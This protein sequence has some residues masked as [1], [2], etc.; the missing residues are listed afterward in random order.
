[1]AFIVKPGCVRILE[2][3]DQEPAA[4]IVLRQA[5]NRRWRRLA[6]RAGKGA[7]ALTLVLAAGACSSL[8]V[9]RQISLPDLP[10]SAEANSLS[11]REHQRV[12]SAYGGVYE[13]PRLHVKLTTIVESLTAHSERPDLHY[14]ITILNSPAVNAFA[15]PSGQLYVTRGLARSRQR[16]RRGRLGDVP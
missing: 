8:Q 10:K 1:V 2:S 11:V 15:L 5:T 16:Q 4:T 13:D 14:K 12:V 7:G 9:G 6:A 3:I